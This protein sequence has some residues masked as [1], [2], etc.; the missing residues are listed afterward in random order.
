MTLCLRRDRELLVF[1]SLFLVA[2][3]TTAGRPATGQSPAPAAKLA[4]AEA[5]YHESLRPQFHFTARYWDDYHIE[6]G[7]DGHE[8]WINDVNG[9]I[10]F[11]GEYHVF[12][13]RWWHCWLHAIS[14]D[15][16]HWEELRPAF[17][18]DEKFGGT[19][20]GTCV[21]D[22]QDVSGLATGATP[23]MIAFWAAVDN[24]RQCISYSNDHGRTWTKY[25][26]NPVLE[27]P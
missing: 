6:P 23:V 18:K 14:K 20:S 8:G 16:V 11:D 9:P 26:K 7:N 10:Y 4:P 13:Q 21:I 27:H 12:G 19:Q 1:A 15:L 5:L 2:L 24:K 22:Y 17:G 3:L 25:A